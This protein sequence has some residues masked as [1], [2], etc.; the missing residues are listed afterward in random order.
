MAIS[1]E[2]AHQQEGA[3]ELLHKAIEIR[4]KRT[5]PIY[6]RELGDHHPFTATILDS[7]SSNYHALGDFHNAKRY[8]EEG[9]QIRHEVL[10]DHMDTAKSLYDLAM[11]YKSMKE[12]TEAKKYLETC[13]VMQKKVLDNNPIDLER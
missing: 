12:F 9:L 1:L 13:E 10:K 8:A 7:L 6:R 11:V 3:H 5:L 2:A 4:E